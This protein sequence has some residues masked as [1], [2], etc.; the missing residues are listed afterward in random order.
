MIATGR[1][2]PLGA[3]PDGAGTNFAVFS[4]VASG[5][6]LCLFDAA[7]LQQQIAYL[8]N[9]GDDIWHGY[10]PGCAAGQRYGYRVHGP[11]APQQGLRCNPA[12]LLIDPYARALSGQFQWHE[13]LLDANAADS[14]PYVPKSV[15]CDPLQALPAG[16]HIPWAET[17]FYEANVRGYTM[18]HP[19]L[20]ELDRGTFEGM[21][22][23]AVLDYLKALGVTSLELLP[24][25]AFLDEKHLADKGLRNFWGYNPIAFFAPQPRYAKSD[26]IGEFRDMVRAMHDAGIE[27]I[28]DVVYNHTA[29]GGTTGPSLSFRGLDNLAYYSTEPGAPGSYIND[30]G[31]GNT[32]DAD[33]PRLQQLVLDSLGYWHRDMGVDG[34]RFDLAPV[35]GRHNH[36]YSVQHPLL[37]LISN[38][39]TVSTAKLIAEPWDPG[40]GGYQLGNFPPRWAEWNDRYRDA[41]RRFWRGDHGISGELANR[42]RGSADIFDRNGRSA[43]SSVNFIASHDGFTLADTVSYEQRHNEAN[44]ENNRDG[45]AHNFSS[46][47]GVEGATDD[48]GVLA[49][50]RQHR[51]NLLATL[52]L[53]QGTPLLLAGD[54][55]GNSQQGNNNAYAQDNETGWLDWSGLENDPEF[56]DQVRQLILLRRATPLLHMQDYLHGNLNTGRS[57]IEI[58][59]FDPDGRGMLD[60]DWAVAE[61]LSMIM[62]ESKAGAP[63]AAVAKLLNRTAEPIRFHIAAIDVL[64]AWRMAF[65]SDASATLAGT[66]ATIP[67]FSI[68]LLL[69]GQ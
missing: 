19:A 48:A 29:E 66:T 3:T 1:P 23:R 20:D 44:G 37:Q 32:L 65:A 10:L 33:H 12:K 42:I 30:T 61:A 41:V 21:R 47:Y 17:I 6:E 15:V 31:C 56:A 9:T 40:P 49:R 16:P 38:D 54:E 11:Y 50:R 69:A 45:H 53:S 60:H 58:N 4:S 55:F 18:R 26:A 52:L 51:L 22:H 2:A 8:H 68:A 13:A 5:V 39:T 27:V 34:F 67:S 7:G 25:H 46:N 59:W 64:G 62:F 36:G 24:V 43:G 14:A 63:T 35:L 28:L 57:F